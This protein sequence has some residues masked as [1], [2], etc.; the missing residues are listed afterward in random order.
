MFW[1]VHF[2]APENS[3]IFTNFSLSG[4]TGI[5]ASSTA[6]SSG[7]L[8]TTTAAVSG[9]STTTVSSDA[10]SAPPGRPSQPP[11]PGIAP[12]RPN[13]PGGPRPSMPHGPG[14][15]PPH[16]YGYGPPYSQAGPYG[17]ASRPFVS[18][19]EWNK[20]IIRSLIFS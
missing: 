9:A 20:A 6:S 19:Y 8:T 7:A 3:P 16:P 2:L 10:S 14:E 4:T 17:G 12:V 1:P 15:R 13:I 11:G 18:G 5:S